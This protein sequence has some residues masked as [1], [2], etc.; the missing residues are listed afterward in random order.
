M[1]SV[2]IKTYGCQMNERDSEA[3]AA[4]L[5]AKGYA[6][7]PS[8]AT[9]DVILLNTCSVR[10]AA[11]Q[12]AI[13]KMQNLAA[14]VRTNRP[15]VVLGFLG[16]MAQSRG[17]QL[18][19]KLP[20]VDL[21][22][23]TQKFHR[24][25]DYLDDLFAGRRDKVVDVEEET[26]SEATIRQHLLNGN[27]PVKSVT[28]FVSIMQGCNQYCT[29]CIVPYTRGEER[30]RSIPDIVAEC[31]ELVAHGV[32]EITLLG[33]IVT[34]YG[35]R[36]PLTPSLSPSDGE[37]VS[38]RS[39]EGHVPTRDGKTAF[40]QLLEAVHEIDGL[41]RIRFTSPHPKGYGDDLVE[42]YG[43]LPKLVESAHL[44]V[45]SGSNRVLKL[46]H[47]G[48]TRERFLGLVEK[49]RRVQPRMGITTDIIVGF[50]G[51][52]EEDFE[53]TLSLVREVEFDNAYMF[54]YSPRRDTPAAAMPNQV[55]QEMKEE[56]NARLLKLVNEIGAQKYRRHIGERMQT[57]VEGP[58]R[59]NP[60][61][62]TGRSRCNKIVL[63]EGADRHRGQLLD[64][65][66]NRAGSFT[67]YGDPAIL[68]LA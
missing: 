37:R 63:F 57:L 24:T 3:V 18:I 34:S 30:S 55:P 56:R 21:V 40:V 39:G 28:A 67:L 68:N 53:Q 42:A 64:V 26:G 17:K 9:A 46:M 32:K 8:E 50:P 60:A 54:K 14:D 36:R 31:R 13:G 45:Q 35:R 2:F 10:D 62:L 44:P 12:K 65:K 20:D 47:R 23:G 22:I 49:L 5:V 4:Q 48:Y 25:A 11:E 41:E 7:S 58:S 59:K 61:R 19:D 66:I 51:E 15:N 27:A 1:P 43:R 33:Q 52:T 38:V 29:F 16:C 6:L